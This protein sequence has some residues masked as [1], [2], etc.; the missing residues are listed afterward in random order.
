MPQSDKREDR[1]SQDYCPEPRL[2]NVAEAGLKDTGNHNQD[3]LSK[4][5]GQPVKSA[6]YADKQGL[7]PRG[8]T[9]HVESVG[10]D[11]VSRAG[12]CHYPEYYQSDSEKR[13]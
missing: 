11:V 4:D 8:Q 13:D 12:E 2:W 5:R 9:E 10:C 1:G 6:A 7:L 3:A